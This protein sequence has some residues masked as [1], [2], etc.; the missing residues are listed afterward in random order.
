MALGVFS[1]PYNKTQNN[2]D[3][4]SNEKIN[5]SKQLCGEQ[6]TQ[7]AKWSPKCKHI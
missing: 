1:E 4:P 3:T 2:L 6:D 7:Q 5:K